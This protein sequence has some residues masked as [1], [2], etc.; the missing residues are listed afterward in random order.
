MEQM[1]ISRTQE[2]F[3][4]T[5]YIPA[6]KSYM[7]RYILAAALGKE[8]C[9]IQNA[10]F[11]NDIDAT[12]QCAAAMGA[13]VAR[14]AGRVEINGVTAAANPP[15]FDCGESASTLRFLIPIAI[16]LCG[17]GHFTG[18]ET[19]LRR[20]LEPYFQIFEQNSIA[21]SYLPGKSLDVKGVFTQ[22]AYHIDGAVSSQF[23]TG[24]LYALPLLDFDSKLIIDGTLESKPYVD[25]TLD[26]LAAAG[27]QIENKG[28][29][30][31]QI[32]GGQRYRLRDV[33]AQ[34]DYSQ[35]AFF[36]AAGL[37]AGPVRLKNLARQTM[38]GDAVIVDLVQKMGGH[39]YWKGDDLIAQ[40]SALRALGTV[41]AHDF[42]DLV[43]VLALICSQCAG[44][45][46]I[47]HIGRLKIKESD[48]LEATKELLCTLG[49]QSLAGDDTLFIRGG[50][51]LTG[52]RVDSRNDHRMA[53]TA[54]VA[55][56][57]SASPVTIL[58]PWSVR[59]SYPQFYEDFKKLGGV[60][61]E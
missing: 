21:Y 57:A 51:R 54:A 19:L 46:V 16:A 47:T 55:A 49:V 56:L 26:V 17:G 24:L 13:R 58:E 37:F 29:R 53:M 42:P 3:G 32:R 39:V 20:P 34:G 9:R 2:P 18:A 50:A 61:C 23:V 10:G 25:I 33:A 5:V 35:A 48:R 22:K 28:Y 44:D 8:A 30:I 45:T 7:H 14:A 15:Q 31:F 60:R 27:I 52:G 6:S 12:L 4:G 11:S 1:T 59:K 40:P 38:Q 43:P 36:L 41:D